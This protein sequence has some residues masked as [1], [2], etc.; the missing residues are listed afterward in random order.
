ML[1]FL[2][3]KFPLA[4]FT[5]GIGFLFVLV[6]ESA[7]SLAM[8]AAVNAEIEASPAAATSTGASADPIKSASRALLTSSGDPNSA[9]CLPSSSP[10]PSCFSRCASCACCSRATIGVAAAG[11]SLSLHSIVAGV[12][13]GASN[14]VI[15]QYDL[16]LAVLVSTAVVHTLPW[17]AL[18]CAGGLLLLFL[19]LFLLLL[20]HIM[21]CTGTQ[22][23]SSIFSHPFS[24]S[25]ECSCPQ[26]AAVCVCVQH[27]SGHRH[28]PGRIRGC[29]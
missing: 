25:F 22:G 11:L 16:L 20:H 8:S 24:H 17:A 1:P 5:F 9:T 21:R 4:A 6:V 14:D 27:A 12:A 29:R 10:S 26:C 23:P 19:L 18:G 28:R 13:L 7:A 3:R 2:C 15:V